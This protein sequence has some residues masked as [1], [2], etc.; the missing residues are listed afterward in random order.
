MRVVLLGLLLLTALTAAHPEGSLRKF[1]LI[2]F[3]ESDPSA[4][5]RFDAVQDG[6]HQRHTFETPGSEVLGLGDVRFSWREDDAPHV[7]F[8]VWRDTGSGDL[9]E[10]MLTLPVTE[11]VAR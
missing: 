1:E 5:A 10:Q 8:H 7:E 11:L 4:P 3:A 6:F 2:L 9:H